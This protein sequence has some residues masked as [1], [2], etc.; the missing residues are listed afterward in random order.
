[1]CVCV[2]EKTHI[3]D[4]NKWANLKFLVIFGMRKIRIVQVR[5]EIMGFIKGLNLKAV[6]L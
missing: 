5:G 4:V 1:M 2:R 6:T 3:G